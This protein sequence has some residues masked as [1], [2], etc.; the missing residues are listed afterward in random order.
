MPIDFF[1]GETTDG[2]VILSPENITDCE[3]IDRIKPGEHHFIDNS[4][5]WVH[6]E[7]GGL[8]VD[9]TQPTYTYEEIGNIEELGTDILDLV[10]IVAYKDTIVIDIAHLAEFIQDRLDTPIQIG[11]SSRLTVEQLE[12]IS[13]PVGGLIQETLT[14]EF[15]NGM[16]RDEYGE[17]AVLPVLAFTIPEE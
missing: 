14:L 4:A 17:E 9:A 11:Q 15:F 7:T 13:L 6:P 1:T 3:T 5:L 16:L 8:Y 2:P 10:R 12:A